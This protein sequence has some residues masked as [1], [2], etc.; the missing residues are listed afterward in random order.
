MCPFPNSSSLIL[1]CRVWRREYWPLQAP[2]GPEYGPSQQ[3]RLFLRAP[4]ILGIWREGGHP[5]AR[6]I[7]WRGPGKWNGNKRLSLIRRLLT[8]CLRVGH[9]SCLRGVPR[10]GGKITLHITKPRAGPSDFRLA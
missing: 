1:S 2:G 4:E 5:V 9:G 8:L 3:T 10:L 7:S 6:G